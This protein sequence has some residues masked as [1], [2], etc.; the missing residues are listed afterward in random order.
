MDNGI[1]APVN[2]A[3]NND[4]LGLVRLVLVEATTTPPHL[5]DDELAFI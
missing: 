5:F 1:W 2:A 3:S 4:R